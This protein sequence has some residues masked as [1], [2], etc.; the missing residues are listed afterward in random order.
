M[1][2]DDVSLV[3]A[4]DLVGCRYRLRQ[5]LAHP[6]IPPLPEAVERQPQ[7]DAG[8]AAV[9]GLL[10]ER[11]ALGDGRR[12]AFSRLTLDPA[13]RVAE[14]EARTRKAIKDRTTLII[15]GALS[16]VVDG[17]AV[18]AEIDI[19]V[20]QD[21]GRYLPV[22]VSNH[23]VARPSQTATMQFIP[24]HRLGLGKPLETAAKARHHTVDGYRVALAYLL[25]SDAGLA[26]PLGAVVG[27]DRERAYLGD[28][29]RYVE[30]L[31][32]ALAKPTPHRPLRL[33][34]CASCRYWALCDPEL[35]KMD[36][37]S[38]VFPGQKARPLRERGITTVEETIAADLGETSRIARAWREG[39]P[40]LARTGVEPAPEL[41]ADVEID[42]D[43]EAYLDQGAYLWGAFDGTDYRAFATWD[44]VGGADTDAEEENFLAFWT[45]L[46]SKRAAAHAG[47]KS[48]R[49]YC[50]AAG[51]ENHWLT[52]SARRFDSVD[53]AEVRAFIASDEWVD[54]FTHVR[55]HLVGTEGLGLKVVAPVAGFTW[56]DDDVDGERSVALRR[57]ARMGSAEA[58][59]MLVRYN[60]D[61]CRATAAVRHFLSAG[62]PGVPRLSSL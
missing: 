37:I 7:V 42:V 35:K 10:P 57:E 48:F 1:A 27:Q 5:R 41:R 61:D 16:G 32:E 18:L 62:A 2:S 26:S 44:E 54:V 8:R 52:A 9:F 39:I 30:A 19:L 46:Q 22:I 60:G 38:L 50:Y 58:R 56:D 29:A 23:R 24:T 12:K 43:M 14:R 25:L 53:E 20:R 4:G 6:E 47:G 34:Q 21:D 36:D 45:W 33:K 59:E 15:D 49:A 40:V 17:I 55:R 51:G 28:A 13:L 3:R 11:R 31:R